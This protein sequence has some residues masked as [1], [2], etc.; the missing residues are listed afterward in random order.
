VC[1]VNAQNVS[2]SVNQNVNVIIN[3]Q[4]P[5]HRAAVV[6]LPKIISSNTFKGSLY[7][8]AV[9]PRGAEVYI[10]RERNQPYGNV[11]ACIRYS[12][13]ERGAPFMELPTHNKE[14]CE[15]EIRAT[16]GM[17]LWQYHAY[18]V[19]VIIDKVY[20]DDEGRIDNW[21]GMLVITGP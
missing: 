21:R 2:Q 18:A 16:G 1:E 12:N 6:R 19:R 9:L 5:Q 14:E 15:E 3:Q 17:Y 13:G 11:V 10:G 4:A 8:G 20:F 7:S